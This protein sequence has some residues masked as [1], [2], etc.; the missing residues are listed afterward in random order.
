MIGIF[1]F[2]SLLGVSFLSPYSSSTK[3]VITGRIIAASSFDL[4]ESSLFWPVAR[5][6]GYAVLYAKPKPSRH[7]FEADRSQVV[8]FEPAT[9]REFASLHAEFIGQLGS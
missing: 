3:F 5:A 1:R 2:L 8:R 7:F 9:P 4:K 6:T